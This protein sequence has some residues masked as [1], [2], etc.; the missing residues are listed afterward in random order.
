MAEP[1]ASPTHIIERKEG[2]QALPKP[3]QAST[4]WMFDEMAWSVA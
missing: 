1:E 3:A 4:V 2:A